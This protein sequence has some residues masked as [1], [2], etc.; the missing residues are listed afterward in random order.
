MSDRI[1][2]YGEVFT[3][4][5]EINAMIKLVNNEVER[6]DSTFLEPACGNGRF[7]NKILS[8]KIN[9]VFNVYKKSDFELKKY[10]LLAVTSL[11]GVEILND[12]VLNCRKNLFDT[13]DSKFKKS[14]IFDDLFLKNIEFILKKN[15]IWGNALNLKTIES[16]KPIVF[17][18]WNFID[19]V[20]I[21]RRD[22]ELSHLLAFAPFDDS[23]LFG[24]LKEN[25]LTPDPIKIYEPIN[26]MEVSNHEKV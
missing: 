21:Q 7:L 2:K 10:T 26:F 15:I 16:D 14:K 23:S 20:N 9:S 5:K 3:E 1:D 19:D 22:Y 25:D 24:N 17:S 18:Q 11:Y 6:I 8:I 13:V 4:E 12:N